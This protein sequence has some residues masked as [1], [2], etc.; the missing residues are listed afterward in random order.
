MARAI[1]ELVGTHGKK[2]VPMW[3][4]EVGWPVGLPLTEDDVARFLVQGYALLLKE[5]VDLLCWYTYMDHPPDTSNPVPWETSFGLHAWRD[6]AKEQ[7]AKPKLA[8]KAH[9]VFFD[10]LKD[11]RFAVDEG[12]TER[13][14]KA[15]QQ[16]AFGHADGRVTR[17]MW[18]NVGARAGQKQKVLKAR[19]GRDYAAFDVYGGEVA[20]TVGEDRMVALPV[21][22]TPVYLVQG[23]P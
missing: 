15:W 3:V 17:V 14:D 2:Q 1:R 9:S 13:H 23:A 19:K 4:T 12:G 11:A 16:L 7:D 6:P 18:Q 5:G 8:A 20:V 10:A 21:G 22:A